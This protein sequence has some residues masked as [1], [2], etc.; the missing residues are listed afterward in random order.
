MKPDSSKGPNPEF[1]RTLIAIWL[2]PWLSPLL[3]AD[4]VK[5]IRKV[6]RSDK[7]TQEQT[8]VLQA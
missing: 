3:D 6:W 5:W 1:H 8:Q 7:E 4:L 2:L